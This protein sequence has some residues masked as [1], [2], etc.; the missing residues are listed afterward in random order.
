MRG[1]DPV[2]EVY[3]HLLKYLIYE[4]TET[5]NALHTMSSDAESQLSQLIDALQS[6]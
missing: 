6:R 4:D 3:E 2:Y 1:D 5:S